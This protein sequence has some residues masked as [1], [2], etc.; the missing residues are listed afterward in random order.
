MVYLLIGGFMA[1]A[2]LQADPSEAGG[3]DEALGT[4]QS[5]PYGPWLLALVAVGLVMYGVYCG[6]NAAYREYRGQ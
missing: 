6:L 5:Q 3:L 1:Q 2:A 4:I